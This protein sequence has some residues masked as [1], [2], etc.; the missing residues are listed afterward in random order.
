MRAGQEQD[1]RDEYSALNEAILAS[2][3]THNPEA[4]AAAMRHHLSAVR[5]ALQL[6]FTTA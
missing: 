4:A 5:R 3:V 6:K 1:G 2:I